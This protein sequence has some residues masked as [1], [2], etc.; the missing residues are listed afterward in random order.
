MPLEQD[1]TLQEQQ[2]GKN[3]LDLVLL[4]RLLIA[5]AAECGKLCGFSTSYTR[6]C[7]VQSMLMVNYKILKTIRSAHVNICKQLSIFFT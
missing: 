2:Q 5:I 4:W 3:R 7:K 6:E 1:F